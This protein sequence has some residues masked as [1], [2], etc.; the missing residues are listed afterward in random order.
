MQVHQYM[1]TPNKTLGT[2]RGAGNGRKGDGKP[3]AK[4]DTT[5]SGRGDKQ[6][7]GKGGKGGKGRPPREGR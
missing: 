2:P 4:G 5:P 3:Y 7:H 6:P 1:L